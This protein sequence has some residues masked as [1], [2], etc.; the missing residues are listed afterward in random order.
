MKDMTKYQ[1]IFP[2]FYACYD[3][4]GNVC[5]D[6][7]CETVAFRLQPNGLYSI[8]KDWNEYK[9]LSAEEK[10]AEEIEVREMFTNF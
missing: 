4:N 2:A 9:K 6:E 5:A 3:D 10:K 7:K 8:N 1:G